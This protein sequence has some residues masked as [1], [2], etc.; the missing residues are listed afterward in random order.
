MTR[1]IEVSQ[2]IYKPN[3][4]SDDTIK[5][6]QALTSHGLPIRIYTLYLNICNIVGIII[7]DGSYL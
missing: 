2:V 7:D 1:I 5:M 6:L 3:W 4:N